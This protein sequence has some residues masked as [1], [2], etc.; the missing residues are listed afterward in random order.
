MSIYNNYDGEEFIIELTPEEILED[1]Q[2]EN[3]YFYDNEQDQNEVNNDTNGSKNSLDTENLFFDLS[4]YG[5]SNSQSHS[6][7]SLGSSQITSGGSSQIQS[8]TNGN[9]Q[10]Q[11]KKRYLLEDHL[12]TVPPPKKVSSA[13]LN[14][15]LNNDSSNNLAANDSQSSFNDNG[16][17]DPKFK[18]THVPYYQKKKLKEQ[19]N[20]KKKEQMEMEIENEKLSYDKEILDV[21]YNETIRRPLEGIHVEIEEK[22][23]IDWEL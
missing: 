3:Q 18:R 7:P 14:L 11:K 23:E 22:Y 4:L 1:Q 9:M 19:L 8:I 13:W 10:H 6:Q 5:L 21:F 15:N 16:H 17:I 20:E 12:V 2:L